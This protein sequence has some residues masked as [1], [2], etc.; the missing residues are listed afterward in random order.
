MDRQTGR[1]QYA[2]GFEE[3]NQGPL[4]EVGTSSED[5][6]VI[7]LQVCGQILQAQ[8]VWPSMP[9]FDVNLLSLVR[10]P[11]TWKSVSW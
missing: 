2:R 10:D 7:S 5:G 6:G 1:Q 4:R 11:Y 8:D 3:R 9:C